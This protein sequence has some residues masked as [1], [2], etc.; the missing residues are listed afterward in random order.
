MQKQQ[1]LHG[2]AEI[3]GA[4]MYFKTS[5][6]YTLMHK[7]QALQCNAEVAGATL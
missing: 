4:T 7:Y 3:A 1:A 2:N 6:R 5:R